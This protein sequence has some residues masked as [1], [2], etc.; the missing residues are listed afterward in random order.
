[1]LYVLFCSRIRAKR[2]A[3][4]I[5]PSSLPPPPATAFGPTQRALWEQL[6]E[7]IRFTAQGHNDLSCLLY[8]VAFAMRIVKGELKQA[9][10]RYQDHKVR[11]ERELQAA[12]DVVSRA[13]DKS[14][15][16][17][18]AW[19]LVEQ[20]GGGVSGQSALSARDYETT[21]R[22]LDRVGGEYKE[23]EHLLL[24]AQRDCEATRRKH[25][26]C[27]GRLCALLE[28]KEKKT[29]LELQRAFWVLCDWVNSRTVDVSLYVD[30]VLLTPGVDGLNADAEIRDVIAK[31]APEM[32]VSLS[33]VSRELSSPVLLAHASNPN[34]IAVAA[35]KNGGA[36]VSAA[37][38]VGVSV[39][40]KGN[41]TVS[42]S[43]SNNNATDNTVSYSDNHATHNDDSTVVSTTPT[44]ASN[45]HTGAAGAAGAVVTAGAVETLEVEYICKLASHMDSVFATAG[46]VADYLKHI[47]TLL[48]EVA[49]TEEVTAKTLRKL[50]LTVKAKYV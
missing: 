49:N 19:L 34:T 12:Q 46:S 50:Q 27:V 21:A 36:A 15:R 1:M 47:C 41:A 44:V 4:A 24:L 6:R 32:E 8:K 2:L 13:A 25:D 7:S 29:S 31:L 28:R 5:K 42:V 20:R 37:G 45:A 39:S 43:R 22:T 17:R 33:V 18:A 3:A 23:A 10:R 11:L 26:I 14:A 9:K 30:K 38:G 48:D 40:T 16:A 35:A